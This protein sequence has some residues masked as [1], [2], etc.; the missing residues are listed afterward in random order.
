MEW[1]L[2]KSLLNLT[3][4]LGNSIYI[5]LDTCAL[6]AVYK[7]KNWSPTA[8]DGKTKVVFVSRYG[9]YTEEYFVEEEPMD[10]IRKINNVT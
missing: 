5:D 1:A 9:G 3:G 7:Y 4:W 8:Q 2:R 10:V 6:A